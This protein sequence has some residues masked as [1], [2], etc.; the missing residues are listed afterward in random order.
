MT[1]R[2]IHTGKGSVVTIDAFLVPVLDFHI[3]NQ[4]ADGR[5]SVFSTKRRTDAM[6]EM[7]IIRLL[8]GVNSGL[9]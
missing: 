6:V 8:W 9:A 3:T 2:P 7:Q 1:S 4:I 5:A